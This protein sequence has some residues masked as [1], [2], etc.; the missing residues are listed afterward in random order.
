MG[1][2]GHHHNE[3]QRGLV[4]STTSHL[5]SVE[6]N[7]QISI[8]KVCLISIGQNRRKRQKSAFKMEAKFSLNAIL[9]EEKFALLSLLSLSL[10]FEDHSYPRGSW[11]RRC[12]SMVCDALEL[13]KDTTRAVEPFLRDTKAFPKP[14]NNPL[15]DDSDKKMIVPLDE[16]TTEDGVPKGPISESDLQ[17]NYVKLLNVETDG[18][19][20]S[21]SSGE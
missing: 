20:S 3:H 10:P 6:E 12:L 19:D 2:S 1:R 16:N 14:S 11:N 15:L 17:E 13:P 5:I 4:P 7:E 18:A 21:V 8:C 9:H